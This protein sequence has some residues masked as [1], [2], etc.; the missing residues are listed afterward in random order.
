MPKKKKEIVVSAP[1]FIRKWYESPEVKAMVERLNFFKTCGKISKYSA[2]PLTI[3]SLLL[4]LFIV[5][6]ILNPAWFSFP[7]SLLIGAMFYIGIMNIFNGLL[8]LTKE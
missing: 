5:S 4:F 8:L 7:K 6:S 3:V 1:F 2:P